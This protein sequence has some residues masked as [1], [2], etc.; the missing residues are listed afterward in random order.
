MKR[1]QGESVRDRSFKKTP[2]I[3]RRLSIDKQS[4][5]KSKRTEVDGIKFASQAEAEY[6]LELK[7]REKTGVI[8]LL[9][10]QPAVKMTYSNIKYVADFLIEEDGRQV[11]IDVKGVMTPVF[12]LKLKLW[13]YYGKGLLRL[14]QKKRF[15]FEVID[16]IETT[17]CIERR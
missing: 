6:Y 1:I 15:G 10:L 4:K 14:V 3:N 16:E 7:F 17:C 2:R 5:Y 12:K 13:R 11:F 9:E 8:K